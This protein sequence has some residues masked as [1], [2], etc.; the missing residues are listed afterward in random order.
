MRKK[1][2]KTKYKY[3]SRSPMSKN[4]NTNI[5]S[6]TRQQRMKSYNATKTPK[7]KMRNDMHDTLP[8]FKNRNNKKHQGR[9]N[10]KK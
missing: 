10:P 2:S 7:I 3:F 5:P 6:K 1:N 4:S 8:I 9:K